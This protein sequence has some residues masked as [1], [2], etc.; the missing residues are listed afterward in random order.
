MLALFYEKKLSRLVKCILI[1]VFA[2][3]A[4]AS[5]GD[6]Q[7]KIETFY[8][9][10]SAMQIEQILDSKFVLTSE[11]IRLPYQ[12]GSLWLRVTIENNAPEFTLYFENPAIDEISIFSQNSIATDSW[13][14]NK[15]PFRDLLHGYKLNEIIDKNFT[16]PIQF[17]LKIRTL[18]P[19]QFNVMVLSDSEMRLKE[20]TKYAVLGSQITAAILL[21]F[22]VFMQN[23]LA[24]SKIFITV[25]I[26]APLFVLSRLNYFGFFLNEVSSNALMYL[27]LN[28][29]LFLTLTSVGTLMIKESFGR[30]ISDKQN[31]YFLFFFACALLPSS[32]L[33]YGVP[34]TYIVMCSLGFNFAMFASL[35]YYLKTIF[36]TQKNLIWR[37]KFQLIIFIA[38]ALLSIL[39]SLY[40]VAPQLFSFKIGI[41]AFRD[42]FYPALAF[43]I[44]VL[45]LNEQ[46]EKEM[47]VIFNLALTKA[48]ADN[49]IEKNE[50][51]RMFLGMLLHEIKTPLSIIKFGAAALTT[52]TPKSQ[53]WT[54]RVDTAADAINHILNQCLLADKYEFGA[55][56]YVNERVNVHLEISKVVDQVSYLNPTYLERIQ[57]QFSDDLSIDTATFVDPAFFRMILENLM[58]NA[59]KYSA[60]NSMIFLSVT[61]KK[62]GSEDMMEFQ[63][64]NQIGKV[65]PPQI[66]KIFSRYYRAAEA[67]GHSGTGLGLWLAN[68]QAKEMG[69]SIHCSFDDMWT[70]FSF[71]LRILSDFK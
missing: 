53:R 55:S 65:G 47:D 58:T 71:Q 30:L 16:H 28:M 66:D 34:R 44:M 50:K 19:K 51:Q 5:A 17:Y 46:K 39:P 56:G 23:W 61:K 24:R 21:V 26:S 64:K 49:E 6:V 2:W 40:Y 68:Q 38:Y 48:K 20:Y 25:I 35:I 70:T 12:K 43:L 31:K 18:S 52:D 36:F 67:Q 1:C 54:A 63:V 33:L 10:S 27:N 69:S 3:I 32:A 4:N 29:I 42:F 62:T 14:A 60:I 57:W 59:L 22:W 45:M 13:K 15:I 11:Q 37:Y 8:D 41:P 7:Y 9:D